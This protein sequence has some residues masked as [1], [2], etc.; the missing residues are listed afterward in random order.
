M[1]KTYINPAI[2]VVKI[3]TTQRLAVSLGMNET[4]GT[5]ATPGSTLGRD[6]DFD[7]EE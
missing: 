3:K 6:F 2:T 5:A 7:D 4:P 1:K